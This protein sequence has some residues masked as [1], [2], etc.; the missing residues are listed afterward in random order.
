VRNGKRG[1]TSFS[2][3]TVRRSTRGFR[4]RLGVNM[5]SALGKIFISHSSTDKP[6]VRR[7]IKRLEEEGFHAWLDE[8]EL[9]VGDPLSEQIAEALRRARVVIVV[10]SPTSIRSRW[11]RYE[12]NLATERMV[13]GM[14]RVIPVVVSE[15][16]LPPEVAGRIRLSPA[17]ERHSSPSPAAFL[18]APR[19][20]ASCACDIYQ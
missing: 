17:T 16:D 20:L 7:L 9:L 14:C 10:V 19:S 13:K 8:K 4:R 5:P 18:A 6:F 3:G 12:L 1:R 11:L 2:H 15:S